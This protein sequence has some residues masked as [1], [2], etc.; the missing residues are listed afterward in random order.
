VS[1]TEVITGEDIASVFRD[2][3]DGWSMTTE[4]RSYCGQWR[5]EMIHLFRVWRSNIHCNNVQ[6]ARLRDETGK[7]IGEFYRER[8]RV[9]DVVVLD[10]SYGDGRLWHED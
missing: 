10:P 9:V 3:R 4:S 5:D 6:R 7:V 8:G 1:K 2:I